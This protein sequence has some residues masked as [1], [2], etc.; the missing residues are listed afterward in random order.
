MKALRHMH[1]RIPMN[2]IL[3]LQDNLAALAG[4]PITFASG[5]AGTDLVV[6]VLG[7]LTSL[8]YEMYGI[9]VQFEHLWAC[10]TKHIAQEWIKANWEPHRLFG[11]LHDLST[12]EKVRD[13]IT[14]TLVDV[15]TPLLFLCGFECDNYSF[16]NIHRAQGPG[17]LLEQRGS[18]GQSAHGMFKIVRKHRP[19]MVILENVRGLSLQGG[20][21]CS[22]LE[23]LRRLFAAMGY[24]LFD[25]L[26]DSVNFYTPQVRARIYMVGWKVDELVDDSSIPDLATLA[27]GSS[28]PRPLPGWIAQHL[29]DTLQAVQCPGGHWSV[30]EFL[31]ADDHVEVR[32]YTAEREA[33]RA[34][35]TQ[36][37]HQ[38]ASASPAKGKGKGTGAKELKW[39]EEHYTAFRNRG[40]HWPPDYTTDPAL[41]RRLEH[42]P[43]RQCQLGWFL[44]NWTRLPDVMHEQPAIKVWDVNPTMGFIEKQMASTAACPTLVSTAQLMVIGSPCGIRDV[45]GVEALHLQGLPPCLVKQAALDAVVH[46]NA[47]LDLAGNAFNGF[48]CGGLFISI[49]SAMD[50]AAV[51]SFTGS[52]VRCG[53]SPSPMKGDRAPALA[54]HTAAASST[55]Q[56]SAPAAPVEAA[57]QSGH[58]LWGRL[59][60]V[61]SGARDDDDDDLD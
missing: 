42:L 12:G 58:A 18:S 23:L 22:D 15:A 24:V 6:G 8:W 26:L 2:Y 29:E 46:N 54:V 25:M 36:R 10:D 33:T 39:E 30:D 55:S 16:L 28:I 49:F 1:E 38:R 34:T 45:C 41:H 51:A 60:A 7:E 52:Q 40:W 53:T 37:E 13:L 32:R 27:A 14:G 9:S 4:V 19:R 61:S 21:Q 56:G 50:A 31:L 20:R 5:C 35:E 57:P 59:L 44:W 11:E 17:S 47:V 48:V 43:E 3:R